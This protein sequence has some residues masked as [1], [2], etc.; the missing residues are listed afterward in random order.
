MNNSSISCGGVLFKDDSVLLVKIKYGANQGMWML[1]GGFLESGESIE[2]AAI[3]EF[4]EET[5][6]NTKTA[7]VVCLRSG[8]QHQN[9]GMQT[10]VYVVFELMLVSG[11]LKKDENEIA[12]IKY[13]DIS[14]IEKSKEIIEL[15]KAI[16]L[17]AWQ[18]KN[19]L[20]E[21]SKIKTNNMYRSYNYYLPN[22][23]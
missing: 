11:T 10:N 20:V 7:R 3:R 4:K 12:D 14:E 2:E 16:I 6:L 5:G 8:T 1:P 15:S 23:L 17:N 21:G 13:W 9:E 19:G 18:T 22:L